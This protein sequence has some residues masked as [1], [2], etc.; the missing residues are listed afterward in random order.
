MRIAV[1]VLV[2]LAATAAA[3]ADQAIDSTVSGRVEAV[4]SKVSGSLSIHFSPAAPAQETDRL[5]LCGAEW[6]KKRDAY[7]LARKTNITLEPLTRLDYRHCMYRCLGG[8][9]VMPPICKADLPIDPP[10][11]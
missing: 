10:A 2:S 7:D 5:A 8:H 3:A 1:I 11:R 6:D 9:T 4:D